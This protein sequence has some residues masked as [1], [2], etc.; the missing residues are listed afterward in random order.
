MPRS[1]TPAPRIGEN[2]RGYDVPV[3]NE[4]AVRAAAGLLFL[5]GGIAVGSALIHDSVAPMQPFDMLFMIDML[6]RVL[7]GDRWSPTLSLGRLIVRGQR[8]E[9][10]GA[11]QK[12]FAWWLGLGMAVLS[13]S[14]MGF[15]A[16]PLG[17][18][19]ALC[20]LC[21]SLLFMESSFG[22]CVGC[23]LQKRLSKQAPQY[24]PGGVCEIDTS[25]TAK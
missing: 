8:P 21:L 18:T 19:V 15:F 1:A 10:V 13:C 5:A 23:A 9:W 25:L 22:I 7:V 17:V 12:K 24:C 14:T 6:L 16:A 4:R 3:I 11:S 2:I 20:S